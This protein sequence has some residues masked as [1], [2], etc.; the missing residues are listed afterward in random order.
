MNGGFTSNRRSRSWRPEAQ[1]GS[2]PNVNDPPTPLP[3]D[4]V[5]ERVME[6]HPPNAA[7]RVLL[8]AYDVDGSHLLPQDGIP[9]E[10]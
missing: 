8:Q 5:G 2:L 1:Y 4:L 3:S 10:G 9:R 6:Q 7:R